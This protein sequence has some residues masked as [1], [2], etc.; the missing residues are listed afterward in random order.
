MSANIDNV[1]TAA[2][3]V[4]AKHDKRSLDK[5][6]TNAIVDLFR[7]EALLLL[8]V[9]KNRGFDYLELAYCSPSSVADKYLAIHTTDSAAPTWSPT[10][11]FISVCCMPV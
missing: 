2:I 8:N 10:I 1:L 6:L 9:S 3:E 11:I 4:T 5:A 7:P